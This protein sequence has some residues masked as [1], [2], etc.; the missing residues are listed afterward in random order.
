MGSRAHPVFRVGV[1][2][3]LTFAAFASPAQAVH[4]FDGDIMIGNA[5]GGAIT[6]PGVPA[7]ITDGYEVGGLTAG[8]VVEMVFPTGIKIH[9]TQTGT[10][11]GS[12]P[13]AIQITAAG[14]TVVFFPATVGFGTGLFDTDIVINGVVEHSIRYTSLDLVCE[15]AGPGRVTIRD[16]NCFR[17]GFLSSTYEPG[18]DFDSDNLITAFDLNLFRQEFLCTGTACQQTQCSNCLGNCFPE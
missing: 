10:Q 1:L 3:M 6:A 8:D 12:C 16:F 7:T 15:T 5:R 14:A 17:Q 11:E 2:A 4:T 18:C 9:A 13:D